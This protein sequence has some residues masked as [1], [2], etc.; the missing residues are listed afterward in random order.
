MKSALLC[1]ALLC[2]AL[3][4]TGEAAETLDVTQ[5]V[6]TAYFVNAGGA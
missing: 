2:S 4:T 5:K 6:G 1:S 3:L